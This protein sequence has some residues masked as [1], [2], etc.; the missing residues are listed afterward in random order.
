MNWIIH[1]LVANLIT[2]FC[3]DRR[4]GQ[5]VACFL[6]FLAHI[7]L[8]VMD[9][10]TYHPEWEEAWNDIFYNLWSG[11]MLLLSFYVVRQS[12]AFQKSVGRKHFYDLALV[13]GVLV[14][15]WDW[16]LL[17]ILAAITFSNFRDWFNVLGLHRFCGYVDILKY[18]PSLRDNKHAVIIEVVLICYLWRRWRT[19]EK[20]VR[21]KRT[22]PSLSAISECDNS[23]WDDV[24]LDDHYRALHFV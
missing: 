7:P 24:E 17:R 21:S 10:W 20:K 1:F 14:D 18:A 4:L 13:F 12:I 3:Y 9:K 23:D 22:S 16:I 2:L 6:S 15:L 5:N 11:A 19:L 8:D